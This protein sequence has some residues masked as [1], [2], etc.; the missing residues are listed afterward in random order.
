M[1][2]LVEKSY[3]G[4]KISSI[5]TFSSSSHVE[6]RIN[7]DNLFVLQSPGYLN[8]IV[9]AVIDGAG[10]RLPFQKLLNVIESQSPNL[11]PSAFASH[12]LKT[13]LMNI[14]RQEPDSSL[15]NALIQA[16]RAFYQEIQTQ[17]NGFEF[18]QL[19]TEMPLPWRKDPRSIRMIL[20]ACTVTLVRLNIIQGTLEFA[21]L[22]DSSLIEIRNN[23]STI[24]HTKD[25]MRRFDGIAFKKIVD[26]Q[27]QRG[28]HQFRDAVS[29]SGGRHFIIESGFHL[30]YVD[31][32]GTTN[33]D[34]GCGVVNGLEE[35][36]AYIETGCVELDTEQTQGI[37]LLTDG[38][39]LLKPL[40]DDAELEE[41]RIT[42]TGYHI[43][44]G[45][46]Q[47]LYNKIGIMVQKDPTFNIYPRTKMQDDATGIYIQF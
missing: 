16:N 7:E 27:R 8:T 41:Q 3:S 45:G 33:T 38:M 40:E 18:S 46:L 37:A 23:N 9:A 14:F 4:I 15:R 36:A 42:S 6:G 47:E 39:E 25:Q 5:E 19:V 17:V 29:T 30:N 44:H 11:T 32:Q 31:E 20:P 26:F 10:T 2:K 24:R 1:N 12:F 28:F 34:L 43:Q 35:M 13:Y 21:N 22:G